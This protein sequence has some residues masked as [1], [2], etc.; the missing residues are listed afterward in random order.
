MDTDRAVGVNAVP[1]VVFDGLDGQIAEVIRP[2]RREE[3]WV[4]LQVKVD[5]LGGDSGGTPGAPGSTQLPDFV[6]SEVVQAEFRDQGILPVGYLRA[7]SA[8]AT[9]NTRCEGICV[10]IAAG[11]S[12]SAVPI[13]PVSIAIGCAISRILANLLT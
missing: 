3:V 4:L 8:S 1:D 13:A 7:A 6:F 2:R 12:I 9:P 10:V 11:I 5:L